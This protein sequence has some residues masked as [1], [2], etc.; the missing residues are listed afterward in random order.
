[1]TNNN[2]KENGTGRKRLVHSF[3]LEQYFK[4]KELG[5]TD[6]VIAKELEISTYTLTNIKK[7]LNVPTRNIKRITRNVKPANLKKMVMF[8]LKN[9]DRIKTEPVL[10]VIESMESGYAEL[11]ARYDKS[12]KDKFDVNERLKKFHN[13]HNNIVKKK[14]HTISKQAERIKELEKQLEEAGVNV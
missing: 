6:A 9:Y 3:D 14:D 7:E 4:W 11:Q 10:K 1:M 12:I 8:K 13:T 2:I 5:W